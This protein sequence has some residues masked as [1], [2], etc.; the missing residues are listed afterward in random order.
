MRGPAFARAQEDGCRVCCSD[1][2]EQRVDQINPDGTLHANDTALLGR[3]LG[4]DEDLAENAEKCEPENAVATVSVCRCSRCKRSSCEREI[5]LRKNPVPGKGPVRLEE[6][7]AVD[8][9]RDSGQA[10]DDLSVDPFAI[11]VCTHFTSAVEIDTVKTSDGDSEHELEESKDEA[12]EGTHH[13]SAAGV[14]ANEV[15]STHFVE[16]VRGLFL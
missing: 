8:K 16:I 3:R 6:R 11:C 15:E 4:V 13:A 10:S 14:V 9:D 12:D 1:E 7:N 5:D 2:P